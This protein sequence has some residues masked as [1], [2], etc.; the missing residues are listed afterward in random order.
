MKLLGEKLTSWNHHYTEFKFSGVASHY[1][2]GV[3]RNP[4][5]LWCHD[6][7]WFLSWWEQLM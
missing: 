6:K 2:L 4:C 7:H 3:H 1:W 5:E